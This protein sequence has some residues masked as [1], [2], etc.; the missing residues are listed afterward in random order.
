[1]YCALLLPLIANFAVSG[2]LID[3]IAIVVDKSIIKDSDIERDIRITEFLNNEPLNLKLAER[4][5]TANKLIDQ[6]FIRSEIRAGDYPT[7]TVEEANT[8]LDSLIKKRY[9]SPSAFQHAL[10]IYGLEETDLRDQFR[11]QL[12]V[13]HFIDSRFKPAVEMPEAGSMIESKV[14]EEVNHLFFSWLDQQ[15]KNAK[16]TFLEEG[17]Q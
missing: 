2:V 14:E 13:L 10:K 8:Q 1:M 3:Q 12:T 5:K 7:A 6:T 9:P 11:W 17:L 16:I 15:H 4:K